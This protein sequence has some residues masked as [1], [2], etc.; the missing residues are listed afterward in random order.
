MK[1]ESE[2]ASKPPS[3]LACP[4]HNCL[5]ASTLSLSR[6][7]N[8]VFQSQG[9]QLSES[10]SKLTRVLSLVFGIVFGTQFF[11][12][13]VFCFYFPISLKCCLFPCH[14]LHCETA[15]GSCSPR[16]APELSQNYP[17]IAQELFPVQASSVQVP[18]A[19]HNC[20]Q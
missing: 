5:L 15:T 12:T 10:E 16:T 8:S 13:T 2:T 19:S 17:H 6:S 9:R 1:S 14:W 18:V 4:H 11:L 7:A 3:H 20:S